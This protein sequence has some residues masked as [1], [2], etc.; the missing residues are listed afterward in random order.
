[1]SNK[2]TKNTNKGSKPIDDDDGY[3]VSVN[4]S[5]LIK[6]RPLDNVLEID[7]SFVTPK[8]NALDI[9]RDKV[10]QSPYQRKYGVVVNKIIQDKTLIGVSIEGIYLARPFFVGSMD[11]TYLQY[12]ACNSKKNMEFLPVRGK[13]WKNEAVV[14]LLS[15]SYSI[16]DADYMVSKTTKEA[17]GG[18]VL[19]FTALQLL[20]KDSNGNFANDVFA[21]MKRFFAETKMPPDDRSS[22]VG[23]ISSM[24]EAKTKWTQWS[25]WTVTEVVYELNSDVEVDVFLAIAEENK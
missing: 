20:E 23:F 6:K 16:T 8:K 21:L 7:N 9:F 12:L 19:L 13:L 18:S 11:S 15:P 4:E 17:G 3:D 10:I 25:P 24:E 2:G 5:Q 22:K 14:S 1:M